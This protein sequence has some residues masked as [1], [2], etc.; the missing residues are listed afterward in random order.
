MRLSNHELQLLLNY[1]T[2]AQSFLSWDERISIH[3]SIA[4]HIT[5]P[6]GLT[7]K[8]IK[9][10]EQIRHSYRPRIGRYIDEGAQVTLNIL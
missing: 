6:A 8:L 1:D 4:R 2:Y 5:L 3:L 9:M 10:H 7:M